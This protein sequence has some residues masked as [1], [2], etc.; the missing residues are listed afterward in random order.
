MCHFQKIVS[1]FIFIIAILLTGTSCSNTTK[2]APQLNPEIP[3]VSTPQS[4]FSLQI[5]SV[6]N[7]GRNLK[8][9]GV[10]LTKA[11][12]YVD[13]VSVLLTGLKDGVEVASSARPLKDF[14][15]QEQLAPVSG[16]SPY[17]TS[18]LGV[19]LPAESPLAFSLSIPSQN[20]SDYQVTLGW[21]EEAV[22]S[23]AA[24]VQWVEHGL[25]EVG[26]SPDCNEHSCPR[27]YAVE[28]SIRNDG[29]QV[30]SSVTVALR[31]LALDAN[32]VADASGANTENE[33]IE[34]APLNLL[35]GASQKVRLRFKNAINP[36]LAGKIKAD[37]QIKSSK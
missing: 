28:G 31:L 23:V 5:T 16:S 7:D 20:V 13:K 37:V 33:Q 34:L 19:S 1:R 12:W 2:V 27:L 4:P 32:G 29:K 11:S 26:V 22:I 6:Q 15:N 18:S 21:G 25:V 17:G 3:I 10:I 30:V 8:V 9:E 24:T 14:L 35:P 36:E